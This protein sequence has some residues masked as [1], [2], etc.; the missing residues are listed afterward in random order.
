V[1]PRRSKANAD[2]FADAPLD[3]PLLDVNDVKTAFKTERGL[4][5]AV[6]GVSFS[7]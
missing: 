3:G 1:S 2:R 5:R 6:D 4:V 7:L